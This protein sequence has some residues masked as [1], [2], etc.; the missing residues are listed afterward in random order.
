MRI[1]KADFYT[2]WDIIKA[3]RSEN[4]CP[5]DKKQTPQSLKKYLIEEVY[6][7]L[8]AIDK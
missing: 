6:E 8:E 1:E 5:W 2:L 3:L 7:V 4:G